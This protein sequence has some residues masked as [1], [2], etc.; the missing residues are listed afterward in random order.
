MAM[1][2]IKK[3]DRKLVERIVES[4]DQEEVLIIIDLDERQ[5]YVFNKTVA[6]IWQ[7]LPSRME[8]LTNVFPENV[9]KETIDLLA[10]NKLIEIESV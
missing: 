4:E 9:V 7:M 10:S 5:G 6:L 8:E 3:V 1:V 2:T